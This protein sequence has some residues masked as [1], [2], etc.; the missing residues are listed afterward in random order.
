MAR[1]SMNPPR[2]LTNRFVGWVSRRKF[3]RELQPA[4]AAGHNRKVLMTTLKVELGAA[5]WNTVDGRLKLLATMSAAATIGCQWCMDFG[6]W[7]SIEDG[8]EP[9]KVT[10]IPQWRDSD[11]YTPLERLVLEYA[12]A[13]TATPP[14]VTD[15]LVASLRGQL[16]D[17]QLVELTATIALENLYGRNNDA[18]GLAPEGFKETCEL[19]APPAR[20]SVATPNRSHA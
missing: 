15:E 7:L 4:I 2:T 20:D 5:K 10:S 3:G 9:E 1:I 16:D 17:A 12:E 19:A 6:Y 14:T 13:M 11:V 8:M 18:L